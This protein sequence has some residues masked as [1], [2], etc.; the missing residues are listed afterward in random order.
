MKL[1]FTTI[2]LVLLAV[3]C[4]SPS[5]QNNNVVVHD[6]EHEGETKTSKEY[7]SKYICPMHCEGSGSDTMGICPVCEM[8]YVLNKDYQE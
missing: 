3:S 8:D 5:T 1:I 2:T 4:S 7:T 6:H